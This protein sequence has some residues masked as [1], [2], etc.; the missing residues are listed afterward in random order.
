M[1]V[2]ATLSLVSSLA[3]IIDSRQRSKGHELGIDSIAPENLKR[4]PDLLRSSIAG[5]IPNFPLEK[6]AAS[7][8]YKEHEVKLAAYAARLEL[9][10][11]QNRDRGR[12]ISVFSLLS[13]VCLGV[14][15]VLQV[16]HVRRLSG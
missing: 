8:S 4:S 5:E 7:K 6:L 15:T 14:A 11:A 2:A 10:E 3:S 1:W 12:W 13:T 16:S 9:L